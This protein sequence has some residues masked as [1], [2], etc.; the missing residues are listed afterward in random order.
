MNLGR[1]LKAEQVGQFSRSGILKIS[2]QFNGL[3]EPKASLIKLKGKQ[4]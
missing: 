1:T 4:K 3:V 2:L